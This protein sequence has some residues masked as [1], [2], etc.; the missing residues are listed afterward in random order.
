MHRGD[1]MSY[2]IEYGPAIPNRYIAKHN[3][4]RLQSMTAACLLI[5]SLAV[6]Q[7]FPAGTEKLRQL[8]L[9]G[10]FSITQE[11]VNAFMGDIR[12]GE[13][14]GDSFTAF[15]EFMIDHDEKLSG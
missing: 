14:L 3:P 9:P 6:R 12:S 15:C 11:A 1:S 2:R 7:F 8:L 5:F 10:E 13:S 4:L